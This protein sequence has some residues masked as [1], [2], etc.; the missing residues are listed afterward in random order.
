MTLP[1]PVPGTSRER[2]PGARAGTPVPFPVPVPTLARSRPGR[3]RDSVRPSSFR[4]LW[5]ECVRGTPLCPPLAVGAE[6][7]PQAV[8]RL[9]ERRTKCLVPPRSAPAPRAAFHPFLIH[10]SVTVGRR[11]RTRHISARPSPAAYAAGGA[12][13]H[14]ATLHLV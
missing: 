12:H 9:G 4:R 6:S 8:R 1:A 2:G 3:V 5:C 11:A 7:D 10:T 14:V 13:I